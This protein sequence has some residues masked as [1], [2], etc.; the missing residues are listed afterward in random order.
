MY[1]SIADQ[2]AARVGVATSVSHGIGVSLGARMEG[3][4][5]SDLIGG[6][7]GRRRP[8]YSIAIEP[9]VSYSWNRYSVG[10]IVPWLVHRVCAPR[11][12][13]T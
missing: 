1:L 7:M 5:S 13:R 11:T 4:P 3:V 9:G 8:A 2:F 10:L 6:D 12:S